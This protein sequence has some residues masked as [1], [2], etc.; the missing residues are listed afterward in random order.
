M[1]REDL[2]P[3]IT[4]R[5]WKI[6]FEAE[7][8]ERRRKNEVIVPELWKMERGDSRKA[9]ICEL[10]SQARVVPHAVRAGFKQ[11]WSLDLNHADP[12]TG[13]KW[14][15]SNRREQMEV[16]QMLDRDKTLCRGVVPSMHDVLTTPR[17]KPDAR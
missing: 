3:D 9:M 11:G 4:L 7:R 14:D 8:V 13:R 5:E 6:R 12:V 10:F 17:A 1:L 2:S 15:L 16:I